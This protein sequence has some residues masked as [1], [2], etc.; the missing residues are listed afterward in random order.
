[1]YLVP[2][3]A[4]AYLRI[5]ILC[6]LCYPVSPLP[7]HI[8]LLCSIPHFR[9]PC[10]NA[11]SVTTHLRTHPDWPPT[12]LW[13]PTYLPTCTL[14]SGHSDFPTTP[15]TLVSCPTDRHAYRHAFLPHQ[16]TTHGQAVT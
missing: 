1:M 6:F 12:H 7:V 15:G 4:C 16:R 11:M 13:D 2:L 14:D 8:A 3:R 9:Y 10:P 5:P